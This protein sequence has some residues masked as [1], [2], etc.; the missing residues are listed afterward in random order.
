MPSLGPA[1]GIRMN[2]PAA[3]SAT[4]PELFS[5]YKG[6]VRGPLLWSADS[7]LTQETAPGSAQPDAAEPAAGPGL[8]RPDHWS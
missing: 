7:Q 3:N 6:L 8:M 1:K 5:V 4:P 2:T